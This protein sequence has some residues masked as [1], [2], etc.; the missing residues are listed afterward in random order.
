MPYSIAS[1]RRAFWFILRRMVSK[2]TQVKANA[3]NRY[4]LYPSDLLDTNDNGKRTNYIRVPT[5]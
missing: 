5:V 4:W 2:W 1:G 3:H